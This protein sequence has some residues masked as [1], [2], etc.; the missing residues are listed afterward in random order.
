MGDH[1]RIIKMSFGLEQKIKLEAEIKDHG[2]IVQIDMSDHENYTSTKT[3]VSVRWALTFCTEARQMFLVSDLTVLNLKQF[4][5]LIKN[6]NLI[7]STE[8]S[9]TL[10][11]S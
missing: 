7:S 2:D 5:K 1:S 3:L 10:K 4:E 11:G 9:G 8:S 6:K